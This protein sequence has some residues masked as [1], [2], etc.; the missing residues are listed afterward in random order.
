LSI[1]RANEHQDGSRNATTPPTS[2]HGQPSDSAPSFAPRLLSRPEDL[3][4]VSLD[5]KPAA[6]ILVIPAVF[7]ESK[8]TVGAHEDIDSAR[9]G[10][11]LE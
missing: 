7:L 3:S 2:G 4:R 5:G 1:L 9:T 11:F 6:H 10:A 8:R